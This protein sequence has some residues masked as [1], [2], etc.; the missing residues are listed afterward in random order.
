M[1][2]ADV[3]LSQSCRWSVNVYIPYIV[4]NSLGKMEACTILEIFRKVK[5]R[6]SWIAQQPFLTLTADQQHTIQW[7]EQLGVFCEGIWKVYG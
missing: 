6:F 1:F 7:M 3:K 2:T 5:F 4:I